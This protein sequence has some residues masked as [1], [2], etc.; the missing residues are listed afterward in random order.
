MINNENVRIKEAYF[1]MG[2]YIIQ[3]RIRGNI[4]EV[5]VGVTYTHG[6]S[7]SN[8]NWLFRIKFILNDILPLL[9]PSS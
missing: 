1:L 5:V 4:L 9:S 3:G 2:Y 8:N 7:N 6:Q